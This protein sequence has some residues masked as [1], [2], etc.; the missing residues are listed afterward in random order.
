MG[1][2]G[3][4]GMGGMG[5]AGGG[6]MG[7]M[8][9]GGNGGAGGILSLEE[10]GNDLVLPFE[11]DAFNYQEFR[12]IKTNKF[13]S[14][15]E[16]K[17]GIDSQK[18]FNMK[19]SSITHFLGLT[20]QKT[21]H[22]ERPLETL[23]NVTANPDNSKAFTLYFND[24]EVLNYETKTTVEALEIV[25]RLRFLMRV[26][27]QEQSDSLLRRRSVSIMALGNKNK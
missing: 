11:L 7:G 14:R 13:G 25:K 22:P 16:R 15:Q 19:P 5:G 20:S 3:G 17:L 26:K 2:V 23:V 8:G 1:G 27:R 4:S 6:G 12:V 24:G 18:I 9:G 21:K 10:E